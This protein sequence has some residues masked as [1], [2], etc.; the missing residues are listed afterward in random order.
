MTNLVV[1]RVVRNVVRQDKKTMIL[2]AFAFIAFLIFLSLPLLFLLFTASFSSVDNFNSTDNSGIPNDQIPFVGLYQELGSKYHI[3]WQVLAAVH[4]LSPTFSKDKSGAIGTVTGKYAE[5][6]NAAGAKYGVDPALL[7]AIAKQESGFNPNVISSAGARG[8]MQLMPANCAEAGLDP[9][10]DCLDP[11]KNIEAGA[12]EISRYLQD[13]NGNLVLA[14]ASYNAGEGNVKRYGGVPPF[15]ETQQYVKNVPLL[16]QQFKKGITGGDLTEVR[17]NVTSIAEKLDHLRTLHEKSV[18]EKNPTTC[19]VYVEEQGGK[20]GALSCAI[21]SLHDSWDYMKRV[22]SLASQIAGGADNAEVMK[23][24]YTGG[25]LSWPTEG[26]I[27]A[28]FG[29]VRPGH[30]HK[31]I[32][33][34]APLGT[35][36]YAAA[37]GIVTKSKA[38]PGGFGWYVEITHGNGLVTWYGHVYPQDVVVKVGQQVKAGQL[39]AK[40][41]D[42]GHSTGAHLHFEV[43]VDGVAKDPMQFLK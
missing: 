25:K 40:V 4:R 3:P 19:M 10:G 37:D 9:N 43:H 16:Y 32:D 20:Y 18:Q 13:Q 5:Y 22:E 30:I 2:L 6:F 17:K 35:P 27:S 24:T 42:N 34:A 11:A 1:R 31:G 21:Y 8:I 33:I 29:E 26:R 12:K 14:L 39:I 7:M 38:D 23:L 28:P 41:G 15:A 36:I